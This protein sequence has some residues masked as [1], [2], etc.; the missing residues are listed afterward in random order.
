M[1]GGGVKAAKYYGA[2]G[3]AS[4][5]ATKGKKQQVQSLKQSDAYDQMI[6]PRNVRKAI[7]DNVFIDG[8]SG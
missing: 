1:N 4:N 2:Q 5:G 8:E 3:G 6:T 7:F